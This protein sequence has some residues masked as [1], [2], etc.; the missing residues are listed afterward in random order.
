MLDFNPIKTNCTG[1]AACFS[2]CP[3]H[4][5]TMQEDEEGFLYPA[6][7]DA[8]IH[9]GLCEK[10]CPSF[11]PKSEIKI[12]QKAVAA[13]S[14]D[15]EV[16]RRS[17]SGGAFS[18]I[19][20]QWADD[21]TLIVGAAWDGLKVHHIGVKGF[22]QIAPLCKSK[23]VS[24]AIEDTFIEVK[25]ALK[26]GKKVIFCGCPCQVAGL[27]AF[28][29][30]DYENLL[31]IDLICHGQ[32]SPAVFEACMR[33]MSD[34]YGETIIAYQFRAK[35]KRYEEDHITSIITNKTKVYLTK[36]PYMQLFLSQ[37]A[38]RP[39]C[40][41]NCK[42]RDIRR[43][44][45]L[46]IADLKGLQTIFPDQ[47]YPKKNRST[48]VCNTQKGADCLMLLHRTME[49]RPITIE[50]V[51]KYNPLFARQT[52]FS[53]D[54]DTFFSDFVSDADSA[55]AKWTVPAIVHN[56]SY[57]KRLYASL[58]VWMKRAISH[59]IELLKK[60]R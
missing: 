38:L 21:D 31:T 43:P 34:Y 24:S 1:C 4:C 19:C 39:S 57:L 44:G 3:V 17:A 30:K 36:D 7:S 28:L 46:T 25:D 54:R 55:I 53:K 56:P 18:E 11:L 15:N 42:Y 22:D 29:R 51:V 50:D 37:N 6:S 2:V 27:K 48:V 59:S 8:C 5:I 47:M 10:V 23:Y 14:R 41:E 35:R 52:W 45:D 49:V 58:P 32:G 9:C 20:R 60:D 16:W 33:N 40:G 26:G 13:V 12:E